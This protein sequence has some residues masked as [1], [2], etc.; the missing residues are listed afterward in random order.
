MFLT[1]HSHCQTLQKVLQRQK[2]ILS[3]CLSM[4]RQDQVLL[5]ISDLKWPCLGWISYRAVPLKTRQME[6][7]TLCALNDKTTTAMLR[8]TCTEMKRKIPL[9]YN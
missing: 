2:I 9:T 1:Q 6:R 3:L 4:G 8:K 7:S 5:Y